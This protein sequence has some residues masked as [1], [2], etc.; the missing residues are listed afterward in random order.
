MSKRLSKKPFP[1]FYA[2]IFIFTVT[3][4]KTIANNNSSEISKK[5]PGRDYQAPAEESDQGLPPSDDWMHSF[6]DTISD[7]VYQSAV[8]FDGFFSHDDSQ[9]QTPQT[10]ARIRLAWEPRSRDLAEFDTRFR[11]KVKLPHFKNKLDLILSDDSDDELSQLP[12]ETSI[13]A[14][15]EI[16]DEPFAAAVRLIHTNTTEKFTDTRLGLSGGDIFLKTRHRTRYSWQDVHGFKIEPSVFYFLDD[17][18]GAR[19]LLEYD[20]QLNKK[21]QF[22]INYSIR[23]SESYSGI[24]W[25]HGF[26]HLQQI[27]NDRAAVLGLLVEG[28]RNGENGFLIDNYTLSYRYRFNALRE[29]LFFDIEPFIE[30][31]EEVDHKTTPGIA[32]RVEGYF[33]KK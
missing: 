5:L 11:V 24:R 29:W 7:S 20:Y 16:N 12:L 17:G 18:L 31:P 6:H 10:T 22:R 1:I 28:E 30:W 8:W 9:E 21:E 23:G 2:V 13:K 27:A 3:S 14:K 15:S 32:L 4:F 25:K 26:Y 33:S 19:L